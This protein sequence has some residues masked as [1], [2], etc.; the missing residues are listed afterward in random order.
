MDTITYSADCNKC[1]R[2]IYILDNIYSCN[3]CNKPEWN[4]FF[5]MAEK[6]KS[7]KDILC[8]FDK[9]ILRQMSISTKKSTLDVRIRIICGMINKNT[10]LTRDL[11]F[12]LMELIWYKYKEKTKLFYD[13]VA[14]SIYELPF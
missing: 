7:I 2:K 1:K 8:W 9:N 3:Y 11:K 14:I 12:E 6:H 4:K 5:K 13:F 10:F